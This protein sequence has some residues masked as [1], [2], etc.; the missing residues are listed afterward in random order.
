MIIGTRLLGPKY[1]DQA[2]AQ[3][4]KLFVAL[5]T[6]GVLF[7]PT[8]ALGAKFR[9]Q[10]TLLTTQKLASPEKFEALHGKLGRRG[11]QEVTGEGPSGFVLLLWAHVSPQLSRAFTAWQSC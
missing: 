8:S 6:S 5:P 2:R 3:V 1:Q 10:H 4:P 9:S 11:Q 7:L